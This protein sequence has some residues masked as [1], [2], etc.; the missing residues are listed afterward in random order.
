[1]IALSTATRENMHLLRLIADAQKHG[2]D[3]QL[4][5]A[6]LHC[7]VMEDNTGTVEIAKEPRIRQRTKHINQ[8]Y[9]H[10]VTFLRKGVMSI[11]WIPSE[12]QLADLLTKP[13]GPELFHRF[14]RLI[15]GGDFP[16]IQKGET[17]APQET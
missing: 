10:F 2:I 14:T 16:N 13:L 4:N 6:E 1:M 5:N 15:C 17:F 8:K 11:N 9:W 12:E 3:L 7:K